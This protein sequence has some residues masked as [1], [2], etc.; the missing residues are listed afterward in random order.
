MIRDPFLTVNIYVSALTVDILLAGGLQEILGVWHKDVHPAHQL[1][2]ESRDM[3]RLI[4]WSRWL[5]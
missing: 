1:R 4:R 5:V 2:M 3:E